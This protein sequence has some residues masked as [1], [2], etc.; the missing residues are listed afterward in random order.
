MSQIWKVSPNAMR[1][2]A[3]QRVTLLSRHKTA[4][5]DYLEHRLQF[6]YSCGR[7]SQ[8]WTTSKA[9][10]SCRPRPHTANLARPKQT[11]QDYRPNK[12]VLIV[13]CHWLGVSPEHANCTLLIAGPDNSK[14]CCQDLCA[15]RAHRAASKAKGAS[16]R[17]VQRPTV[18]SDP[19]LHAGHCLRQSS[20]AV[21]AKE[22]SRWLPTL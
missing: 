21:Q 14:Q 2:T 18:E 20:G 9:A 17:S 19:S 15:I 6:E 4:P 12:Q 1:A 22:T 16:R 8:I 11:H 3:S 10:M 7:S 5:P 13:S